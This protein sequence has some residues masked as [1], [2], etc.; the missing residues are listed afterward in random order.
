M[1]TKTFENCLGNTTF[2]RRASDVYTRNCVKK[3][4]TCRAFKEETT[5]STLS[6]TIS[7][8]NRF[9]IYQKATEGDPKAAEY[10]FWQLRGAM[11]RVH[12]AKLTNKIK[13][14]D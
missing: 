12:L 4:T 14:T 2:L 3:K 6:G 8:P 13:K 9:K 11:Q 10:P 1:P 7:T 5:F